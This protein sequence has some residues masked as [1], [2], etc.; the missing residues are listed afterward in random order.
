MTLPWGEVF[1]NIPAEEANAACTRVGSF[2]LSAHACM[3][4]QASSIENNT[5]HVFL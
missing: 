3:Q 4:L 1:N 5:S 2:G